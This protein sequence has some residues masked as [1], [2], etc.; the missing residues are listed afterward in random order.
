MPT[1]RTHILNKNH[2]IHE[3]KYHFEFGLKVN[4]KA[5]NKNLV[6]YKLPIQERV[7]KKILL[8]LNEKCN[9]AKTTDLVVIAK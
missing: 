5:E 9:H 4:I 2:V 6:N 7:I 1:S 3:A 8:Q